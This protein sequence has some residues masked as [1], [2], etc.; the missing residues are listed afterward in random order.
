MARTYQQQALQRKLV[1]LSLVVVLFS[2]SWVW[3]KYYV[4]PH[5][6]RHG[7]REQDVG[8]VEVLGSA[9]RL[10]LIGMRGIAMTTLWYTAVEKKEK[11]QWNELELVIGAITKLQ[12]HFITPWQFQG[13]N[14]TYNVSVESDRIRDKYFYVTRGVQLLAEGELRNSYRPELRRDIGMFQ[15]HKI[16]KSDE[17]NYMRSLLQLSCIPPSDRHPSRFLEVSKVE[18]RDGQEVYEYKRGS[19]GKRIINWKG[20]KQFCEEHPQLI[21]RLYSPPIVRDPRKEYPKFACENAEQVIRF[22]EENYDIPSLWVTKEDDP[23]GYR[24]RA[25]KENVLERF[26]VL[27]DP[28]GDHVWTFTDYAAEEWTADRLVDPGPQPQATRDAF[29]GYQLARAWYSY[30]VEALPPPHPTMPWKNAPVPYEDRRFKRVPKHMQTVLYRSTPARTQSE[31][32]ERLAE[33]GWF[34][35]VDPEIAR[36]TDGDTAIN[37]WILEVKEYKPDGK[38][39]QWVLR[40]R[41]DLKTDS[42]AKVAWEKASD[43]WQKFARRNHLTPEERL[44]YQPL[45]D[46]FYNRGRLLDN[47]VDAQGKFMNPQLRKLAEA[48]EFI[49]LQDDVLGNTNFRNFEVRTKVEQEENTLRARKKFYHAELVRRVQNDKAASLKL[50]EEAAADFRKVLDI[51]DKIH[52]E[53]RQGD[54]VQEFIFVKELKYV[55]DYADQYGAELKQHLALQ[56][57]L[58]QGLNG[59]SGS[60]WTLMG[61]YAD[62]KR[63]PRMTVVG[64]FGE[65]LNGQP[66]YSDVIRGSVLEQLDLDPREAQT[67]R[68]SGALLEER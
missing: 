34:G 56:S 45:A 33:E 43:M 38:A 36:K 31:V 24:D 53:Y 20:Y 47:R 32:A 54:F 12:P 2:A 19:D 17:N 55:R 13:W 37:A 27:P 21:R 39:A 23:D 40:C 1:Y 59:G 52:R 64:P 30:A 48:A 49:D 26:P 57:F 68:G 60:E 18:I 58:A 44:R 16:M 8:E 46:E 15:E 25:P 62:P 42:A 50:F 67:A 63:L 4:E 66:Y 11:H 51:N 61:L 6:R 28:P 3:G 10:S 35:I 7:L 9:V 29:D 14:L 5:A 22:L 41:D 65:D